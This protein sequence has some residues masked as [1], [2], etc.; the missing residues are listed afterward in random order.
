MMFYPILHFNAVELDILIQTH[1]RGF[2][3]GEVSAT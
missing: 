2:I 1:G 3:K